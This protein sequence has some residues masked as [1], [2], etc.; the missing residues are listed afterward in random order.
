MTERIFA[1]TVVLEK[2]IR[3]DDS[4]AIIHAIEMIKGVAEVK[5]LIAQPELYWAYTKA[6]R[7]LMDKL[8]QVLDEDI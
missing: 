6:R 4:E 3:E 8:V 5:P 2:D 7:E 1:Y